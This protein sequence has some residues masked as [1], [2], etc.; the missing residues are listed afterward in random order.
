MGLLIH[1]GLLVVRQSTVLSDA[2]ATRASVFIS[3][4]ASIISWPLSP[5][6]HLQLATQLGVLSVPEWY[7]AGKAYYEG[8]DPL[9]FGQS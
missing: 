8:T 4:L 6:A 2:L 1:M 5:L 3:S 7:D 9:P